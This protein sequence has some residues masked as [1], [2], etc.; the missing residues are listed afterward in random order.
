MEIKLIPL[1]KLS[2]AERAQVLASLNQETRHVPLLSPT[3]HGLED[4]IF[5]LGK[6][7]SDK[8]YLREIL[9]ALIEDH[10][11]DVLRFEERAKEKGWLSPFRKLEAAVLAISSTNTKE[12]IWLVAERGMRTIDLTSNIRRTTDLEALLHTEINVLPEQE[13]SSLR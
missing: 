13:A 1:S 5:K 7:V 8:R 12:G 11:Q 9:V 4:S 10:P 2:Q 6:V 3:E